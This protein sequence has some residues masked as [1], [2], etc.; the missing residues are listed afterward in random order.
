MAI[1]ADETCAHACRRYLCS[2]MQVLSDIE[3]VKAQLQKCDPAV[4]GLSYVARGSP[5]PA[6]CPCPHGLS[7]YGLGNMRDHAYEKRQ[8]LRPL[9]I[10]LSVTLPLT[11]TFLSLTVV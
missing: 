4:L 2:A 3:G 7:L 6:V 1:H 5:S 8:V 10:I 11:C 9:S